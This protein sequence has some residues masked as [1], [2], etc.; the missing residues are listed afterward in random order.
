LGSN[1]NADVVKRDYCDDVI[2]HVADDFERW[3]EGKIELMH[4]HQL[5]H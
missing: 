1:E 4:L 5:S 2:N 3:N